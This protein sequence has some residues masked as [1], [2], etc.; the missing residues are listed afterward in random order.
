MSIS[1]INLSVSFSSVQLGLQ[2]PLQVFPA[3]KA[4]SL[5]ESIAAG[6]TAFQHHRRMQANVYAA[7]C[8]PTEN[9]YGTVSQMPWKSGDYVKYLQPNSSVWATN[10]RGA[11]FLLAYAESAVESIPHTP[12]GH[13]IWLKSGVVWNSSMSVVGISGVDSSK[14]LGVIGVKG[15][16]VG[17]DTKHVYWSGF[18]L[19]DF[20]PS[21]STGAGSSGHTADIGEIVQLV[22]SDDG[23]YI[24][25]T[26]GALYAKCTGDNTP[27]HL[28]LIPNFDGVAVSHKLKVCYSSASLTVFSNSGLCDLTPQGAQYSEFDKS[29]Q[30][31]ST[32]KTL[33]LT[34]TPQ[35]FSQLVDIAEYIDTV[36]CEATWLYFEKP[37]D[38]KTPVV[39]MVSPNYITVSYGWDASVE[40]YTRLLVLNKTL[41][42]ESVLHINHTDVNRAATGS[43]AEFILMCDGVPTDISF[44]AG[45]GTLIYHNLQRYAADVI[46]I[47]KLSLSGAF[48]VSEYTK[49]R[50]QTVEAQQGVDILDSAVERLDLTRAVTREVQYAGRLRQRVVSMKVHWAGDLAGVTL[51][52][53]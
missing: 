39:T 24:L 32:Y 46:C 3:G 19:S 4:Q 40:A 20:T 36:D 5:P 18:S 42:R 8:L 22:P 50:L 35:K 12:D 52:Y 51:E 38:N 13:L 41:M 34:A 33:Q 28:S 45:I 11:E 2:A 43:S 23:F 29:R 31:N 16:L 14:L 21:L 1:K 25:G 44:G 49:D 26:R 37:C 10:C 27:F 47:S 6:G 7:D 9:G 15:R 30:L 53:A 48:E 17:H